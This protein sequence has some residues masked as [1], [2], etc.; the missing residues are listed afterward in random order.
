MYENILSAFV[1]L[2]I[3][4]WLFLPVTRIVCSSSCEVCISLYSSLYLVLEHVYGKSEAKQYYTMLSFIRG[5]VTNN[6]GF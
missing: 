6:C 4:K 3:N 2:Y 5:C 1:V